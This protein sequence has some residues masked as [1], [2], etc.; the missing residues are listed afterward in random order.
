MRVPIMYSGKRKSREAPGSITVDMGGF[1]W[2]L[3]G[4]RA[5]HNSSYVL[6][7]MTAA[8]SKELLTGFLSI[9]L[10]GRFG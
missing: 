4:F 3:Q 1:P 2:K 9:C 10:G 7:P 5:V 6:G 8:A